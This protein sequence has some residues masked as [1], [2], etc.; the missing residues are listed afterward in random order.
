MHHDDEVNAMTEAYDEEAEATGWY[1][2]EVAFGLAYKFV[3]PGQSILDLGIGTGLAA[4]LFR[5][6]GLTVYGMDVAPDML[7]ACRGKGF[8]DLTLHDLTAVPYPF[9]TESFDHAVCVGTLNFIRDLTPVFA[10]TARILRDGGVFVFAV[11][12][13]TEDEPQEVVVGPEHTMTDASVTM[14][15]HSGRQIDAWVAASGF[16]LLRTLAFA[17]PMDREKTSCQPIRA[18]LVRKGAEALREE[19][20]VT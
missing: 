9:P 4:V 12:D 8:K 10:E 18:Y 16:T 20:G 11:G 17:V 3:R 15:R 2:P 19:D 7:D 6:A 13:R 1:G 5:Q 14:Y